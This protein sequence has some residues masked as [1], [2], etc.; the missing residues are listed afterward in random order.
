MVGIMQDYSTEIQI[1]TRNLSR[2]RNTEIR[3]KAGLM[4]GIMTAKNI[5]Y[6]CRIHGVCHKTFY[7]W[8][9]KFRTGAYELGSSNLG[10]IGR[11]W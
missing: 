3:R 1:I 8:L 2:V 4:L 7:S 5:R 9:R 10:S 6:G 11:G